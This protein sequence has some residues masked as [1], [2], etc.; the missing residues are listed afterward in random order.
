[1]PLVLKSSDFNDM[2]DLMHKDAKE[3]KVIVLVHR[4]GCMWCEKYKPDYLAAE[5][6]NMSDK[7]DSSL[8]FAELDTSKNPDFI[9]R[10]AEMQGRL[11]FKVEGVPTILGYYDGKFFSM[12]EDSREPTKVYRSIQ[13]TLDYGKGIGREDT[14]ITYI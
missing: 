14:E 8:V 5:E 2:F 4:P 3:K 1:M 6:K 12:Y 11:P 10:V 13:D 9:G 7:I